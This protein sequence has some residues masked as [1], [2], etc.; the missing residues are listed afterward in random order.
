MTCKRPE[1][2]T[3]PRLHG[4]SH[5][6]RVPDGRPSARRTWSFRRETT[7]RWRKRHSAWIWPD[8]RQSCA[9]PRDRAPVTA[10][11]EPITRSALTRSRSDDRRH[12]RLRDAV[13]S[14]RDPTRDADELHSGARDRASAAG[15]P[16]PKICVGSAGRRAA[17]GPCYVLL[18]LVRRAS[19]GMSTG[20]LG[21]P[22]PVTGSH[23][24]A[25]G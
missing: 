17:A 23:P 18:G 20:A 19:R 8:A 6:R 2:R 25:A 1:V 9:W 16:C 14:E 11:Q 24:G 22:Q 5:V 13:R 15:S 4:H 21:D 10:R 12:E 7:A 3:A